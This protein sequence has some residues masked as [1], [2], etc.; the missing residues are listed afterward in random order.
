MKEVYMDKEQV[1]EFLAQIIDLTASYKDFSEAVT[2]DAKFLL[3][4]EAE[5]ERE[6]ERE[7]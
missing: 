7:K 2:K 5:D 6:K 1:I 3:K 4:D